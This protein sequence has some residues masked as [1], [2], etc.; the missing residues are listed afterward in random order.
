[1]N[2]LHL[3]AGDRM[4]AARR[5]SGRRGTCTVGVEGWSRARPTVAVG[6]AE[7]F[8]TREGRVRDGHEADALVGHPGC[9]GVVLAAGPGR[10]ADRH[11]RGDRRSVLPPLLPP[12]GVR[13]RPAVRPARPGGG[14]PGPRAGV[15]AARPG[16][17]GSRGRTGRAPGPAAPGAVTRRGWIWSAAM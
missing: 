1:P 9:S 17:P 7:R 13:G 12:A 4:S 2:V 3:R 6:L 14:G 5:G 16:L 8:G 15:R 10:G 11:R